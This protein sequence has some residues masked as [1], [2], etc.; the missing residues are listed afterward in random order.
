MCDDLFVNIHGL[1]RVLRLPHEWL[2]AEAEAGRIPYLRIGSRFRF[3]VD[4]VKVALT[5]QAATVAVKSRQPEGE[6]YEEK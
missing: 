4:A 3:S 6:S 1:A 2:M 5:E